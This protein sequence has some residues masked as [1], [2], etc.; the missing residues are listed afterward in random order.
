MPVGLI[1]GAEYE[2]AD[3]RL[4]PG[5]KLVIYTDGV[6]EAQDAGGA[7]FGVKRLHA[8]AAALG[9]S[10]AETV[11]DAVQMAV[12]DFTQGAAQSDDITLLV[13]EYAG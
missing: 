12:R 7:F 10:S 11:H 13:L 5:D 6:T 2:V 3:T 8:L 9:A 1:E 4:T